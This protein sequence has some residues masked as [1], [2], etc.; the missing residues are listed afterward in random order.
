MFDELT[1]VVFVAAPS[2]EASFGIGHATAMLALFTVP[3][4]LA[5]VADPLCFLLAARFAAWRRAFVVVG[6]VAHG[7]GLLLCA[8]APD[9]WALGLGMSVVFVASSAGTGLAEATLVDAAGDAHEQW[10][11]RWA[12]VGAV[13]DL[14]APLLLAGLAGLGLGWRPAVGLVALGILGHAGLVAS[15]AF[16]EHAE[17]E[18]GPA[19]REVLGHAFTHPP[20]LAWLLGA[21]LCSLLDETFVALA[22]LR[23]DA[24]GWTVGSQGAILA[25]LTGASL[26]GLFATERALA[27]GAEPLRLLRASAL[28][29]VV[30]FLT[31]WSSSEPWLSTPALWVLGACIGPLWPIAT[32]Q[33]YR[34][35]PGRSAVVELTGSLFTPLD[36]ILPVFLGVLADRYGLS[37]ALLALLVQPLGLLAIAAACGSARRKER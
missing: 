27:A 12:G 37:A 4:A 17:E 11:T 29:C 9:V 2:L 22:A 13:G 33:A 35:L 24:Q 7:L 8:L 14:L 25:G 15:R 21:S 19:L 6:L 30:A 32:A 36:V 31:W 18:Q 1:G 26:I 5:A 20:L 10:M 23:L 28:G 3:S 16:P 34:A